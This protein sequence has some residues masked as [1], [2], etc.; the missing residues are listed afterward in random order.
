[1]RLKIVHKL[2][3]FV[4]FTV[5]RVDNDNEIVT[6]FC[7]IALAWC[8]DWLCLFQPATIHMYLNLTLL[9]SFLLLDFYRWYVHTYV[10]FQVKNC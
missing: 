7:A 9:I 6:V 8:T 1:M 10:I 2:C 5:I 3:Q 4:S